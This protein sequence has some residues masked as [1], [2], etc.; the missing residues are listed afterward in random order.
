MQHISFSSR[1]TVV[2]LANFYMVNH[3]TDPTNHNVNGFILIECKIFKN[4]LSS[5]AEAKTSGIFYN[6]QTSI[7]IY[8]ILQDLGHSQHP[9]TIKTSNTTTYGYVH[10]NIHLK[11]KIL[12]YAT[13]LDTQ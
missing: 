9:T 12:G 4:V 10:N 3:I 13:P 2:L 6:V 1:H 5:A 8:H 7:P 11:I